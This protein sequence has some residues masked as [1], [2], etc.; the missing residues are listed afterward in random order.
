M[1][2]K[3][4]DKVRVKQWDDL[5]SNYEVNEYGE[6][7]YGDCFA[8]PMRKY[9]GE[10]LEIRQVNYF[11][12]YVEGNDW[13]WEDW[14]FE[15]KPAYTQDTLAIIECLNNGYM[16]ELFR[17]KLEEPKEE[18]SVSEYTEPSLDI[19]LANAKLLLKRLGYTVVNDENLIRLLTQPVKVKKPIGLT[20]QDDS[21][22]ENTLWSMTLPP[23][24]NVFALFYPRMKEVEEE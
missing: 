9:C 16:P 1:T 19:I 8:Y 5:S 4:G 3:V 14:M 23:A 20:I 13:T 6:I 10:E 18:V 12:Y 21:L 2:Y 22:N 15:N 11:N 24:A 17:T 7:H